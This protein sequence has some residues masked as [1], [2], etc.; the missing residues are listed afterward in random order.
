MIRHLLSSTLDLLYPPRCGV[1]NRIDTHLCLPCAA[2]LAEHQPIVYQKTPEFLSAVCA[3][4]IHQGAVRDAVLALKQD[5]H[6]SLVAA[7]G[8][9]LVSAFI[10]LS[11]PVTCIIPVP[12]HAAR[13][14]ERGYNQSALLACYL[15]ALTGLPVMLH[16][17]S[18]VRDTGHQVGLSGDQRR[19]NVQS[20][21][22]GDSSLISNHEVLLIDDVFTTGATLQASAEAL[23]KAGAAQAFG[24]TVTAAAL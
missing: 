10:Q 6:E 13:I 2:L 1:C 17:L 15:G 24:L 18:R 7:L 19:M 8:K 20:A 14:R 23:L 3:T 16:A 9:R 22:M 11:W 5:N 4:A 21:F 12:L